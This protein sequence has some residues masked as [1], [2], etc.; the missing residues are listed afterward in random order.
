M[1]DGPFT[2]SIIKRAVE[3]DLVSISLHDIRDYTYD[4]HHTA[5]DYPYGGGAGMLMKPEPLFEAVESVRKE[6]EGGGPDRVI[7]LTPQGR[8]FC[9]RV[10]QELSLESNLILLCGHYEG[11]DERVREYLVTDEIS[12]GEYVLTGGELA[13]MVLVDAVVRLIPGVL[14]SDQATEEESYTNGLLEY[15]QYT[16]PRVY[17]GWEVPQVLLSGNHE[18]VARWRRHQAIKRTLERQP[19]LIQGAA[20]SET[21]RELIDKVKQEN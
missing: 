14:G 11:V 19:D 9:H 8:S 5:D 18:E 7:L 17:R 10:A 12:I 20:L 16:R 6:R 15:P 21:E 4:K 2:Q 1:F 3:R 13:A